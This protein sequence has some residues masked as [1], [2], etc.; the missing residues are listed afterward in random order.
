MNK[1]QDARTPGPGQW[2]VDDD[3]GFDHEESAM[4]R[5]VDFLSR[6][7]DKAGA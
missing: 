6:L 4:Q 5:T 7:D 3:G 2:E 1:T